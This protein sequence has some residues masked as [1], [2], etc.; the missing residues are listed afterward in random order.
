MKHQDVV[1]KLMAGLVPILAIGLAIA[2][3]S[4]AFAQNNERNYDD[5]TY[6]RRG[7]SGNSNRNSLPSGTVIPVRLDDT[8]SSKTA[9]QGDKFGATVIRGVDDAGLPEGTRLEGVVRSA[10]PS[11]GGQAGSLDVDFRRIFFPDGSSQAINA[12]LYSL[13]GKAVKR[14]DGRLVATADKGKDRL[15][16]IGIGAGA[17]L[18]VG[19]L[20]KQNTLL[21]LLLGAGAGY[22]Y[23]EVGNKPKPGDV[24]LKEGQEFG[25][26]LDSQLAYNDSTRR[27]YRR[28]GDNQAVNRP[29]GGSN[30]ANPDHVRVKVNGERVRFT[31]STR[32]YIRS[33]AVFVPLAAMGDAA[34]FDYRYDSNKRKIYARNDSLSVDMGSRTATIDGDRRT[35]PTACEQRNGV[36][37][38]PLQFISWAAD[39]DVGYDE[40]SG[41]VNVNTRERR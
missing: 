27:Y 24:N 41:T 20:T 16:F 18:I 32:P 39:S 29:S 10:V 14:S 12:S 33:G 22:L 38:V 7:T 13:S 1:Q 2:P 9:S 19:T 21:S 4:G 3:A 31:S 5:N 25:V 40:A 17:G 28:S 30:T 23:N 36:T 15:K 26:R 11:D 35:L 8:L 6:N 37:F 34:H